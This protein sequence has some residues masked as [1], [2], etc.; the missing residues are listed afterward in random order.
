[1]ERAVAKDSIHRD[2]D[3]NLKQLSERLNESSHHISQVLNQELGSSFYTWLNTQRVQDAQ[4]RLQQEP[5]SRVLDIAELV[6][7]N[8]KSTFNTAFRQQTG[9]TP[10]QYR[11]QFH[12]TLQTAF[13]P[14]GSGAC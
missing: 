8:A 11:D 3:L 6:G 4:I 5:Q 9:L 10:S 2:P 12:K 14:N 7:F 1:L 13:E